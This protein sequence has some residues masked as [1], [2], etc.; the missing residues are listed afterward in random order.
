M[1]LCTRVH[2]LTHVLCEL[3]GP[4]CVWLSVLARHHCHGDRDVSA[5]GRFGGQSSVGQHHLCFL[6]LCPWPA[7]LWQKGVSWPSSEGKLCVIEATSACELRV[8]AHPH[9]SY[10]SL[11]V[12]TCVAG[13]L[14]SN[15]R[16]SS[17][18]SPSSSGHSPCGEVVCGHG[19]CGEV[20]HGHGPCGGGGLWALCV[21]VR[22]LQARSG[23][24]KACPSLVSCEGWGG[25][26]AMPLM[27]ARGG[28]GKRPLAVMGSKEPTRD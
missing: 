6:L 3:Y 25:H 8:P 21:R 14:Y 26:R 19:T 11:V 5:A 9:H 23:F 10:G 2:F 13:L 15:F 17:S 20:V 18:S 27:E 16:Q 28:Y 7:L 22:C 12:L 24:S 1:L 4:I